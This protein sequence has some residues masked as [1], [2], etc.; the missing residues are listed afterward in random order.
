[1]LSLALSLVMCP[2]LAAPA[3]A[4][5]YTEVVPARY[6]DARPFSEGMAA[7]RIGDSK[8][9]NGALSASAT[10]PSPSSPPN[11]ASPPEVPR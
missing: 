6:D 9:A 8:P 10:L 11:S 5:D 3:F 4:A 1:M 2:G 7:V